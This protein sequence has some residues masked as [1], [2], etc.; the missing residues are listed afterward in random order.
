MKW[1][2]EILLNEETEPRCL[3]I[4]AFWPPS[5]I[6]KPRPHRRQLLQSDRRGN[7][8][9]H[10]E[11]GM[12][13]RQESWRGWKG[14]DS[15]HKGMCLVISKRFCT[16]RCN[17]LVANE[18]CNCGPLFCDPHRSY[19]LLVWR[20]GC[21]KATCFCFEYVSKRESGK[22]RFLGRPLAKPVVCS[23]IRQTLRGR[24]PTGMQG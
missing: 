22:V 10:C 15:G 7:E 1:S 3:V 14:G 16:P 17:S 13:A 9:M 24:C 4:S 21:Q 6:S 11:G 2:L 5:S 8:V 23:Y 12:M 19:I 20:R 18:Y